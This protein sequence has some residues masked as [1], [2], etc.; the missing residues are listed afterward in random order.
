MLQLSPQAAAVIEEA[1]R[2]QLVPD[3]FGVRIS[4]THSDAMASLHVSFTDA[5]AEGDEVGESE[6]LQVFVAPDLAESLAD[7]LLDVS[8]NAPDNELTLRLQEDDAG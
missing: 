8:P 3:H 7:Q 4:A 6:G 5:P 2:D 1:R